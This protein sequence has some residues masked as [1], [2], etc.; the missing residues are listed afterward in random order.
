MEWVQRQAMKMIKGRKGLIYKTR[1]RE[2]YCPAWLRDSL[3]AGGCE[4]EAHWLRGAHQSW[5]LGCGPHQAGPPLSR[6]TERVP[7]GPVASAPRQPQKPTLAF[8]PA[9]AE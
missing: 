8:C 3:Q 9:A 5:S 4:G 6:M 1:L 7:K 2:Q